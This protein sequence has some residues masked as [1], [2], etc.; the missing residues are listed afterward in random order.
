MQSSL[1]FYQSRRRRTFNKKAFFNQL[2]TVIELYQQQKE[3]EQ[4]L[5]ELFH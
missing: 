5:N 3:Y 4:T 2:I 1:K